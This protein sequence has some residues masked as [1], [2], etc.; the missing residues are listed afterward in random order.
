MFNK[1]DSMKKDEEKIAP[2]D[3][4]K[5]KGFW[6]GLMERLDK[7]IVEEANQSSCCCKN[8]KGGKC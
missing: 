5:K 4:S 6:K 2:K 3:V 1:E 7:K 8:S